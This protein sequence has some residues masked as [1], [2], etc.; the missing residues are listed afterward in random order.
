[1]KIYENELDYMIKM[2]PMPIYGKNRQKSFPSE[3]KDP[4]PWN[5][6]CSIGNMSSTKID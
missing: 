1:M 5:L 3:A 2:A 4:W 6:V